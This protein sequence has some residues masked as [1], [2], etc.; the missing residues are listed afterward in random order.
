[1]THF[2][3]DNF[4]V[5]LHAILCIQTVTQPGKTLNEKDTPNRENGSIY[6]FLFVADS[7]HDRIGLCPPIRQKSTSNC[8]D[9]GTR[10]EAMG[11]WPG[12][13]RFLERPVGI[14]LAA[15]INIQGVLPV[16]SAKSGRIY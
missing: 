16:E 1:M 9:G 3:Q 10:F 4:T 14:L 11:F 13:S 12:W 15:L 2:I 7:M 8:Q 6:A 5:P